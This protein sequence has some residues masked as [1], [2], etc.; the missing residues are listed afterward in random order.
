[1]LLRHTPCHKSERRPRGAYQYAA[2]AV[3]RNDGGSYQVGAQDLHSQLRVHPPASCLVGPSLQGRELS[4]SKFEPRGVFT[5]PFLERESTSTA[6]PEKVLS[7]D[8]A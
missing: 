2:G 7:L 6:V 1:M 4:S 8:R 3:C 5:D